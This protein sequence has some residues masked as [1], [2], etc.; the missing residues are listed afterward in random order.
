MSGIETLGVLAS[1]TQLAA[2]SIKIV[3]HLDEIYSALQNTSSRTK[4]QLKQVKELIQTTTLIERHESLWSPA[5]HRQLQAT[6]SE[7]RTLHDLLQELANK[8]T[9]SPVWK[10]WSI[11]N[12][13]AEKEILISLDRLER[14][15]STLR[16]CIGAVHTDLLLNIQGRY[17]HQC[18]T[19]STVDH[20]G[21]RFGDDPTN[22]KSPPYA[23][24]GGILGVENSKTGAIS[25]THVAASAA[26]KSSLGDLQGSPGS[27]PNHPRPGH[28][29]NVTSST[30]YAMQHVGD[31]NSSGYASSRSFS[32]SNTY[33]KSTA[34]DNSLQ[35]LGNTNGD[36][37]IKAFYGSRYRGSPS[38]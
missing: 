5:V 25:H 32:R 1:A 23:G 8:Y 4:G 27:T 20:F 10:Y 12:G 29:Y 11:L 19:A 33:R 26:E 28:S 38:K 37:A 7:A 9:R 16:L 17:N 2:Y 22:S 15:K 36:E 14:E 6:L 18:G 24:Y 31:M 21:H 34:D 35:V 30:K 3:L 13:V